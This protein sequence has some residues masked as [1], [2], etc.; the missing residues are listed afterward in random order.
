MGQ[1][2]IWVFGDVTIVKCNNVGLNL[3]TGL[4]MVRASW[5]PKSTDCLHANTKRQSAL[6]GVGAQ[7]G[8][9]TIIYR[10]NVVGLEASAAPAAFILGGCWQSWAGLLCC[11]SRLFSLPMKVDPPDDLPMFGRTELVIH[12]SFSRTESVRAEPPTLWNGTVPLGDHH[13]WEGSQ[14]ATKCPELYFAAIWLLLLN[15][16]NALN[17]YFV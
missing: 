16:W 2:V 12:N 5:S 17:V 4:F 7:V 10:C 8:V 3:Q 1:G 14:S 6:L 9:A 11:L 15:S 13:R